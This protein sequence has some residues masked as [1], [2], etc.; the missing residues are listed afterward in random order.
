MLK[1]Q[2]SATW[3]PDQAQT[4]ALHVA[5]AAVHAVDYL[6]T[7]NCRHIDNPATKPII[8]EVCALQGYA[9]PE[10]CTP[11]EMRQLDE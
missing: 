2:L 3:W 1:H 8:R 6:L 7:W 5:I 11:F 4:D 10:I 9:C